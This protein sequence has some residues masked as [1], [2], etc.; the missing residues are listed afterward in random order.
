M[1][2]ETIVTQWLYLLADKEYINEVKCGLY[3]YKCL[4]I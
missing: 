1:S 4:L 2:E 3:L